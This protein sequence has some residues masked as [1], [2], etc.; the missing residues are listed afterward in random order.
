MIVSSLD[1]KVNLQLSLHAANMN[2]MLMKQYW[3]ETNKTYLMRFRSMVET[4]KIAGGEHMLV[5]KALLGRKIGSAT[6][7]EINEEKENLIAVCYI[8]RSNVDC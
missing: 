7:A 3:N 8:L 4:L 6:K 5:S 2:Y 1:T